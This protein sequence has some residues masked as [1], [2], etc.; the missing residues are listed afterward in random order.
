M[1]T[2]GPTQALFDGARAL[3][4]MVPANRPERFAKAAAAGADGVIVD[5]ED[6]VPEKEKSSARAGLRAALS[7]LTV[8]SPVLV[9]INGADTQWHEQD[10]AALTDLPIAGVVLS[11]SE[12]VRDLERLS[13]LLGDK[14]RVIALIESVPGLAAVRTLAL[15]AGR[16]AFGSFDFSADLGAAHTRDALLAARF[17][18]LI[19]SRLAGATAAIN[20]A[21]AIESDAAHA[22]E[23]GFFGKLLIHPRQ[24]A[25]AA[26]GL[27]PAADAISWAQRVVA[28]AG[29]DALAVVDEAMVDR[30]VRLRAEWILRRA[31]LPLHEPQNQE[32]S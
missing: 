23:L 27:R 24:V 12:R 11:K 28:A 29:P 31:G 20:D 25:P 19:A 2:R 10:L 17:E 21:A 14:R 4:L 3:L 18:V 6:A 30:P 32:A 1:V 22:A 16:L 9:R 15:A 13:S 5:L 7:S 8:Q 26:K